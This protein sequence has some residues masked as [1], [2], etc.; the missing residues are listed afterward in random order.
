MI[1]VKFLS[2]LAHSVGVKELEID[3]RM[4]LQETLKYLADQF[5]KIA[6]MLE[7]DA[8]PVT[9]ILN[10]SSLYLPNDL[11]VEVFGE[12]IVSPIIAGG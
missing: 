12:L 9:L 1:K 4:S 11:D 3:T 6:D 10:G 2:F 7:G 5:P 8:P